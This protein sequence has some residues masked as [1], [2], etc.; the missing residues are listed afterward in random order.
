[1]GNLGNFIKIDIPNDRNLE[2]PDAGTS[3]V[4]LLPVVTMPG[5]RQ[6]PMART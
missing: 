3:S 1:M 5:S 6:A 4:I 2:N